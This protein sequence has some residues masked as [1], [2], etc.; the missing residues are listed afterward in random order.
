MT[1]TWVPARQPGEHDLGQRR[2]VHLDPRDGVVEQGEPLAA[3]E[4]LRA[5]VD[6]VQVEVVAGEDAGELEPDVADPEDGDRRARRRSGSEEDGHLAAAALAAVLGAGLVAEGESRLLGLDGAGGEHRPRAVDG[7]RLE[8]AAADAAP[9]RSAPTTILAP[10]SR[11]RVPPHRD[12]GDE[13]AG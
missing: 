12:E 1:S 7:G 5:R 3:V 6:E 8:V 11:G 9:R 13:H 4:L 2:V 10:A